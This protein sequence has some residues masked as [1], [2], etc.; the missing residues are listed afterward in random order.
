MSYAIDIRDT[1]FDELRAIKPFHRRRIVD[2]IDQQLVHQPNVETKNR[3]V[4]V[5]FESNFDHEEP[6]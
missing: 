3:K 2:S 1:A 5:G 4:L 6:V